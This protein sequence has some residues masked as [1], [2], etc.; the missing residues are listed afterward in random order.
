MKNTMRKFWVFFILIFILIAVPLNV[1]TAGGFG[2]NPFVVKPLTRET[3]FQVILRE[4]NILG[5]GT[6]CNIGFPWTAL[7][8]D[9]G[10]TEAA[11]GKILGEPEK[12]DRI[13]TWAASLD[14]AGLL[15]DVLFTSA[16]SFALVK[17]LCYRCCHK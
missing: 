12:P 11:R 17:V 6:R 13:N 1:W 9:T 5:H 15:A 2:S 7:T 3:F 4:Q 8:V 14:V 16:L 10:S